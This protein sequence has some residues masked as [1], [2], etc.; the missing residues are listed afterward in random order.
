MTSS[1]LRTVVVDD[2]PA[3]AALHRLFVGSHPAFT[4]VASVADGIAAI[5]TIKHHRPDLVLLDFYLPG[6][7]GL[8]VLRSVRASAGAQPEFI[9]VTAAHDVESV[10]QSRAAGIRHY[11][12]KPFSAQ[13]LRTRLDDVAHNH[14]LLAGSAN[15]PGLVQAEIDL[16][17]D[18]APRKPV[19]LPKGLRSETLD[20]VVRA[21]HTAPLSSA[22]EIGVLAG[23]SRVSTRRYLEFLVE[24]RRAERTLDY[25]TAG[26]PSSRYGLRGAAAPGQGVTGTG[27]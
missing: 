12:V 5:A 18:V 17:M 10:R 16:L 7:S 9:A 15:G 6:V 13:D 2:D 4:V 20:A 11:L 23:I 27:R 14:R 8:E 19:A 26:R 24:T 1:V 22:S 21:L 3:V 25:G